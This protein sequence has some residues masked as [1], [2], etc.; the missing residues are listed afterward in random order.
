M[1]VNITFGII[2]LNGEPFN[3]FCI[4][5]LYP[6]AHEIIIAE[7]ACE[8]ARNIATPDGHSLDGTLEVL[9]EI[10]HNEDPENKITIITAENEGYP[11]GFWP[12][13]KLEQCQAYSRRAKGNYIWHVDIDEFYK[14]DDIQKIIRLLNEDGAVS[15][16]SFNQIG[17]WGGFNYK[18]ESWYFNRSLSEIYRI[19]K[20]RKG[21][22]FI[23]HR[24]PVI[25]DE[26]NVDVRSSRW[27]NAKDMKNMGIFMYH[28]S[29]VFPKQVFTKADYYSN[30]SWLSLKATD[31]A[32]MNFM[33]ITKPFRVFIIPDY[34]SWL[35][36]FKGTHPLAIQ[37]L[38][39]SLNEKTII[40]EE[41]ETK[42]IEKLINKRGYRFI[43]LLLA[44]SEPFDRL[45]H[46]GFKRTKA[47]IKR[48]RHAF[49]FI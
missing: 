18:V 8:G 41:R 11:D 25:V 7:G 47:V 32:V 9:K 10:K 4:H 23:S 1:G 24:P 26:N 48:L 15:C 46:G 3:R 35:E 28:Y 49:E 19:F 12:G 30:S 5:A 44:Y 22:Q 17:F 38:I 34:P 29:F 20:W 33:K 39:S 27:L 36:K 14:D 6:Y 37:Q 2:V 40:I 16:I 43:S 45:M 21:Y 31:W 13:E 42:D